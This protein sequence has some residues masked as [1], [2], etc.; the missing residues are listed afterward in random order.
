MKTFKNGNLVKL[1]AFFILTVILSC[2]V[3]YAAQ[4]W[5]GP[6][7]SKPDDNGKTEDNKPSGETDENT[8]G[9]TQNKVEASKP[10]PEFL[11]YI[12]GL[13]ITEEEQHIKPLCFTF[14]TDA[15]IYGLSSSYLVVELPCENGKT[16]FAAFFDD[17][18]SIGK[19]GS[20]APT[21]GYISNIVSYFGGLPLSLGSDQKVKYDSLHISDG[22]LDISKNTGYHYTEYN[23]YA[24]TNGDLLNALIKNTNISTVRTETPSVP[25]CFA[26]YSKPLYLNGE[27]AVSITVPY[28]DGNSTELMYSDSDKSYTLLKNGT[29]KTDLINDKACKYDNV[30][31][32]FADSTTYETSEYTECV[33]NT[34]SSG[35]GKYA[36]MGKY[37]DITWSVDTDGNL[38][39]FDKDSKKLTV[40][41]G[42]SYISF[43]K[44]STISKISIK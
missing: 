18:T 26:D 27:S 23:D 29:V 25:Y 3:A 7:V 19:I 16:R 22:M 15:P 2:T 5:H 43:T 1:V 28:S 12:T 24:Y 30:F 31:I 17:A 21:R 36:S 42:T 34:A 33:L 4:D 38:T 14:S 41:R 37:V 32:L 10:V 39:F 13:E 11:H 35:T 6:T 40:N 9:N 8:D 44:S 20:I